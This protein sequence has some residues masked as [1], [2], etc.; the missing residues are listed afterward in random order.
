M[1]IGSLAAKV[2]G[3]LAGVIR[4]IGVINVV[5][6]GFIVDNVAK[7][8]FLKGLTRMQLSYSLS[9]MSDLSLFGLLLY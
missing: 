6:S 7:V 3:W 2:E 8:V 9:F 4:Q 5:R 1:L